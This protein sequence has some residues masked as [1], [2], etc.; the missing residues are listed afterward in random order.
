MDLARRLLRQVIH[1]VDHGD[2]QIEEELAAI[3]HLVLHRTA[4]LECVASADDEREIMCSKF[5]V[6]VRRVGIREAS[7]R[8]DS[9]ALNARLK[10]LLSQGKL[11]QL[12]KSILVSLAVD[13]G[14]LEDRTHCRVDDGFGGAVSVAA[15][16]EVPCLA[17]GFVFKTWI[18]VALVEV[19]EN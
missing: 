18:V 8:Q 3:L 16:L 14:I 7:R 2:E 1:V 5:R 12:L 10:A 19:L 9:G 4:A 11:L 13:D 15:V 17:L 6:A